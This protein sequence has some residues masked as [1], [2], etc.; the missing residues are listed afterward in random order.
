MSATAGTKL[1]VPLITSADINAC[2]LY[3]SGIKV[4][5]YLQTS[6]EYIYAVGDAI[7]FRQSLGIGHG[8][9]VMLILKRRYEFWFSIVALHKLG[10]VV[11]DVYKRQVPDGLR[12]ASAQG[13]RA[14]WKTPCLQH[15]P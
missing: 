10:A 11:I 2:L 12:G 7:E 15:F 14:T 4:N 13:Q 8:D 3:T 5:D 9:M 1:S 6:D